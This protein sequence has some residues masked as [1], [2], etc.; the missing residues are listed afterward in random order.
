MWWQIS[1]AVVVA[2]VAVLS[3]MDFHGEAPPPP[4]LKEPPI[5]IVEQTHEPPLEQEPPKVKKEK[6]PHVTYVIGDLHGDVDCGKYWV[7]RIGIVD[8]IENPTRWLEKDASLVFMGDYIDKG[9]F[10]Y[11]TMLFVKSLTDAFPEKVTALMGNHEMEALKD[12]HPRRQPKYMHYAYSVVHPSEFKNFV[13][14]H[15]DVN[16]EDELVI[17]LLLNATLEIYARQL[18]RSARFLPEVKSGACIV[19]FVPDESKELVKERLTE[20]QDAYLSAFY[21]NTTLGKWVENLKVAHVENGVIF[22]HGGIDTEIASVIAEYDSVDALNK[23]V[24]DNAGNERFW[25]FLS[26]TKT[27]QA[28]EKMLFYRGNHDGE[29]ACQELR[30][31]LD[32]MD[33]VQQLAVG[34]TPGE[35]IRQLCGNQ[36]LALDSLLGRWIRTSGNYYCPTETRAVGNFRCP[37]LEQRCLGQIVKI[38]QDGEV[39]IIFS[40]NE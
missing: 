29:A 9:P 15:R 11:Q 18:Q 17:D 1:T 13:G 24:A 6:E 36:F 3:M 23:Y 27:G 2:V 28:V 8:N 10:S 14:L 30:S 38:D 39:D 4:P 26:T 7:D 33:G 21:S 35:N 12:R 40:N 25:E 20:Y 31:I 5:K 22:T 32:G 37:D 16:E 19:D 34:H